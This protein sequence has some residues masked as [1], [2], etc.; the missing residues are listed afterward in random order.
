MH[1]LVTEELLS[2][3]FL[4]PPY[5]NAF[6]GNSLTELCCDSLR[7]FNPMVFL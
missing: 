4:I 1:G 6:N 7:D 2:A 5:K 3:N